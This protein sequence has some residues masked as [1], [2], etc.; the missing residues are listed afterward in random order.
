[1]GQYPSLHGAGK[2]ANRLAK[3]ESFLVFFTDGNLV[4][5]VGVVALFAWQVLSMASYFRVLVVL[6][7]M[8]FRENPKFFPQ[9]WQLGFMSQTECYY[10]NLINFKV[11]LGVMN[12][13]C[14]II[15]VIM[16]ALVYEIFTF[17]FKYEI[18]NNNG[19]PTR[20]K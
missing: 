15:G 12:R 3:N 13:V 17:T 14:L 8:I 10:V 19:F 11:S 4:N 1:M 7:T 9:L 20:N 5:L 16:C 2:T 18:D 6:F